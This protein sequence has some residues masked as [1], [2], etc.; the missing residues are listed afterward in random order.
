MAVF[1]GHGLARAHV[2]AAQKL[3]INHV[4]FPYQ[5]VQRVRCT[6]MHKGVEA[7]VRNV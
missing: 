4:T 1:G 5:G 6:V 7:L 3:P 2:V